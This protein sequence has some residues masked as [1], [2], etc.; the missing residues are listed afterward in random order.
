MHIKTHSVIFLIILSILILNIKTNANTAVLTYQNQ[1]EQRLLSQLDENKINQQN[2]FYKIKYINPTLCKRL[3]LEKFP[4]VSVIIN[5]NQNQLFITY[6]DTKKDILESFIKT[7]DLKD[8]F[9]E[10]SIEIIEA[11][12]QNNKKNEGPLSRLNNGLYINPNTL[13]EK[14]KTEFNIKLKNL[15]EEGEA[16]MIANPTFISKIGETNT[17]KFGESTPY[18]NNIIKN[19]VIWQEIKQIENGLNISIYAEIKNET[20]IDIKQNI[21]ISNVKLWKILGENNYPVL[22][23]REFKNNFTLQ[24]NETKLISKLIENKKKKNTGGILKF[25]KNK[26]LKKIFNY[27]NE[28]ISY[29]A[30]FIFVRAE[31][32]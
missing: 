11:S 13:N 5:K 26:L 17:I 16:K 8:K 9:I 4:H 19:D 12:F 2:L 24:N 29:S 15:I 6:N 21:Q 31:I 18:Q 10:I 22:S 1:E 20:E 3:I 28:E 14:I 32:L 23:K 7:I 27:S 30:I 25:K